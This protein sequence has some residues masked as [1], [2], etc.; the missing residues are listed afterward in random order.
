VNAKHPAIASS[1]SRGRQDF[2]FGNCAAGPESSTI[3]AFTSKERVTMARFAHSIRFFSCV[4]ATIILGGTR[5]GSIAAKDLP[6]RSEWLKPPALKPGDTIAFVAPAGPI[7]MAQ[8]KEYAQR[9]ENAGYHVEIPKG[10]ERKAGYLA[11]TDQE[12]ADELNAAIHDPK[13]RAIFPCRGGYGLTRILDRIDYAGLRKDP[14]IITGFSDLTAL[15]LAIAREA[16][17]VTFHSPLPEASLWKND[18]EHAFATSSFER[19]VFA[20]RYTAESVGY[21]IE[22]PTD[23]PRPKT[24]VGG[25]ARGRLIGGNLTLIS[26]TLGTP[27]A[28]ESKGTILFIE[29][30]HEAP[31]RIDRYLSQLRLAGILDN[32]VGVVAGGFS[33]NDANDAKEIDRV[34]HEYFSTLKKP[35]I[36]NFPVGHI[37]RN[38]TLPVGGLVELDGDAGSMRV[39][40]NPVR[41][42]QETITK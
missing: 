11:G 17:V 37:T 32:I 26:T 18:K 15:H 6:A 35:V 5:P 12:R 21:T 41:L 8:V 38:A 27:Y 9:L 34:L 14:K 30:V 1:T 25:K 16:R 19:A 13:V 3:S 33:S 10:I 7:E 28:I 40:E 29:D 22:L 23:Q 2:Y 31:Y 24:L 42:D 39:L 20:D 36:T 4:F